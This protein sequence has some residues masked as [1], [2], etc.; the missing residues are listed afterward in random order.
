MGDTML[1][2]K[3]LSLYLTTLFLLIFYVNI[4][5]ASSLP[6]IDTI[7]TIDPGHGGYWKIQ[8]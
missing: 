2:R 3:C 5:N 6:L 7:I 4:I 8:K 1:K